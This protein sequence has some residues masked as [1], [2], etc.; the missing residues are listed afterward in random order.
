MFSE[1][2]YILDKNT[3]RLMV[4]EMRTENEA[5]EAKVEALEAKNRST[6]AERDAAYE[7]LRKHGIDPNE[8]GA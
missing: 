1:A 8:A 7:L 6:T 4:D 3:E 2:L 5:L